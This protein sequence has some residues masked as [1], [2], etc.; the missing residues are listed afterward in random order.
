MTL[1]EDKISCVIIDD[2]IT[3]IKTLSLYLSRVSQSIEIVGTYTDPEKAVLDLEEKIFD[4]L[5]CDIDMPILNGFLVANLI[6]DKYLHLV[7]VTSYDQYAIE[8]IKIGALDYLL[9]PLSFQ[10][11]S[12]FMNKLQARFFDKLPMQSDLT[13][14]VNSYNKNIARL[15]VSTLNKVLIFRYEDI[16]RVSASKSYTMFHFKNGESFLSSRGLFFYEKLLILNGFFKNHKSHL[17][18]IIHIDSIDVRSNKLHLT[19]G[20]VLPITKE[21]R[22]LLLRRFKQS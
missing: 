6:R 15:A 14:S 20:T 12:L 17:I 13:V 7:F 2:D 8:A 16:I 9:K 19:D 11:L 22:D 5:F 3:A 1:N 4:V 18:N 21:N 10:D